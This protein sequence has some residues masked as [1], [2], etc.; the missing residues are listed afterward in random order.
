MDADLCIMKLAKQHTVFKDYRDCEIEGDTLFSPQ[1]TIKDGTI[2][3]RN[4]LFTD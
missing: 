1:L 2:V 3:Y 4:M